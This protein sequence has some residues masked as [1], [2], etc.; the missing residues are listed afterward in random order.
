MRHDSLM[1]LYILNTFVG[2]LGLMQDKVMVPL[3]YSFGVRIGDNCC[4]FPTTIL[5]S[6]V[7]ELKMNDRYI[8]YFKRSLT[9]INCYIQIYC[10][11]SLMLSLHSCVHFRQWKS[12]S[13]NRWWKW[14]VEWKYQ[15]WFCVFNQWYKL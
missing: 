4:L 15:L 7:L 12:H 1:F 13:L 3:I 10:S 5:F 14:S 6:T 9:K 8:H 11:R 2:I